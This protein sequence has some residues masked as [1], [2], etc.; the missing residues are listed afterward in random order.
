MANFSDTSPQHPA[1]RTY[2][3]HRK[4]A[5]A[6]PGDEDMRLSIPRSEM[7]LDRAE[8]LLIGVGN[9]FRSDD[10]VGLHIARHLKG[11]NLP[12]V[13]VREASGE[14]SELMTLWQG[15][16]T[17]FLFDA[18][19]TGTAKPGTIYRI[20]VPSQAVPRHF[21]HYSTHHFSVAEAIELARQLDRLPA[22]LILFGIEGESFHHGTELSPAVAQ[23][24]DGVIRQVISE[25]SDNNNQIDHR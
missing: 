18:V 4:P 8:I 20:A 2:P 7:P 16:A 11:M 17:V 22:S 9:E 13:Q 5:E 12:Y 14:G 6:A 19:K 25:L 21:F 15:R 24:S 23:A 3:R 10:A 1:R